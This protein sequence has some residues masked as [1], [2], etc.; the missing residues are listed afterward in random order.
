MTQH[1]GASSGGGRRRIACPGRLQNADDEAQAAWLI[2]NL[3]MPV[4]VP[5]L[6]ARDVA[7]AG[8]MDAYIRRGGYETRLNLS[9]D[10]L[11]DI[12]RTRRLPTAD[13]RYYNQLAAEAGLPQASGP[14]SQEDMDRM[15]YFLRFNDK[16]TT[17]LAGLGDPTVALR[18][19]VAL[20]AD[21]L[22]QGHRMNALIEQQVLS[23]SGILATIVEGK[24]E[25]TAGS[26]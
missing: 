26:R 7:G 15:R 13:N 22:Q 25:S 18:E 17:K 10:I 14:V 9:K 1:V 2:N 8:G 3:T 6:T 23:M 12:F 20:N 24:L 5:A 11:T 21:Q 4:P 19:V 16:Y